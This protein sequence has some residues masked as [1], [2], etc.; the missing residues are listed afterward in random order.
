MIDGHLGR[1]LTAKLIMLIIL[2][3][4]R[5]ILADSHKTRTFRANARNSLFCKQDSQI[6]DD[7][8]AE[9]ASPKIE[10]VT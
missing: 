1:A 2:K 3:E 10:D 8:W 5:Q 7:Y 9:D 6:P 4:Q